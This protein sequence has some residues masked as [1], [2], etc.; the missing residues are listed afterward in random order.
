MRPYVSAER[1]IRFHSDL[2][3]AAVQLSQPN[4]REANGVGSVGEKLWR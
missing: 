3:D 2:S 1:K 4:H